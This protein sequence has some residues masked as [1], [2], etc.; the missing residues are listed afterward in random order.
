M[1]LELF[2]LRKFGGTVRADERQISLMNLLV[3]ITLR[4]LDKHLGTNVTSKLF[5]VGMFLLSVN[6]QFV[7]RVEDLIAVNAFPVGGDLVRRRV[8]VEQRL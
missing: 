4:F 5:D 8:S 6:P 3:E 2:P 7:E 1:R